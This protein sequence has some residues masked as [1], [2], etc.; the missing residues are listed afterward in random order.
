MYRIFFEDSD[1]RFKTREQ[2]LE[3]LNVLSSQDPSIKYTTKL[4][5]LT[6]APQFP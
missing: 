3:F 1:A 5:K 4:K 6:Q 2:S